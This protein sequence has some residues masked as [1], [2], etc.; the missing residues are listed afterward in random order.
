D[1]Y[2][3]GAHRAWG[4]PAGG[5]TAHDPAL[6]RA[7]AHQRPGAHLAP[8]RVRPQG[9]RVEAGRKAA[10]R[11]VANSGAADGHVSMFGF[12]APIGIRRAG[13]SPITTADSTPRP[14]PTCTASP[15]AS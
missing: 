2:G 10:G 14:G 15:G 13:S 11:Y 1:G 8:G 3:R 12:S 9:Q 6:H 5:A 4:R 7:H